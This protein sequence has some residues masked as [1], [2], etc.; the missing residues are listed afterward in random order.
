[1]TVDYELV[2]D[3][4]ASLADCG[5]LR[6]HRRPFGR[7]LPGAAAPALRCSVRSVNP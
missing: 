3:L 1:L 5:H 4:R 7:G 2:T 6:E